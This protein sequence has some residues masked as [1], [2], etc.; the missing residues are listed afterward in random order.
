MAMLYDR[1]DLQLYNR[2]G[3]ESFTGSVVGVAGVAFVVGSN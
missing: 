3:R 2:C 1:F